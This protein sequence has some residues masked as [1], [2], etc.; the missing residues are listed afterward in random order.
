VRAI[1]RDDRERILEALRGERTEGVRIR[2]LRSDG[3]ERPVQVEV[4]AIHDGEGHEARRLLTAE[5]VDALQASLD[6]GQCDQLGQV[7]N[8]LFTFVGVLT[9]DGTLVKVN[10][11]PVEAGGL[12]EGDV[13]GKK[14]WDCDW[15]NYDPA[16][17]AR[18]RAACEGAARGVSSRYDV[19]VRMARG[20]LM[21][22]DFMIA[23][24][25]D[26]SGHVTHLVPSGVDVTERVEAEQALRESKT[27]A[28][29]QLSE[30][31]AT[32]DAAPIGLCVLDT[33]LRWVRINQCLAAMN[34]YPVEAHIGR[35][36]RELLPDLAGQSEDLLRKI[37]ETGRPVLNLEFEGET[38]AQPGVRRAWIENFLPIRDGEGKIV[39]I[40]VVCE[41]ITERK[42]AE[43]AL[44]RSHERTSLVLAAGRMGTWEWDIEAD[45][46]TWSDEVFEMLRLERDQF[47]GDLS[48]LL[49][50]IVP[51]DRQNAIS[52]VKS[53]LCNGD[54]Y[55]V[56]CRVIRAD[57]VERRIRGNGVI[58]RDDRGRP[59]SV[60]GI[61]SDQ[62]EQFEA[63]EALRR[64]ETRLR[65]LI[66]ANIIGI[67]VWEAS[68]EIT[69]ANEAFLNLLGFDRDDLRAGRVRWDTLTP[70]EHRPRALAA[71]E[72]LRATGIRPPYEKEFFRKDGRTVPVLV[73]AAT[74][75]E[76]G[77]RPGCLSSS[78]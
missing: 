77:V 68:G 78:T 6:R 27:T 53:A 7:L 33:E 40:N 51:E 11:A 64:S 75:Q 30:I 2:L 41:E 71:M 19:Q 20:L 31:Q 44:R 58:R 18:L 42:K 61:C 38:P 36:V 21:T 39:G 62:T 47:D 54:G 9:P 60:V 56:E 45:Q 12:T 14:F 59:R 25:Y 66:N 26:R 8:T 5:P 49:K 32:Y 35:S 3:C 63:A 10:N 73:S 17:Q 50:R 69:E 13:L 43:E 65:R 28:L 22:V 76:G 34:G 16:V 70:P 37:L 55:E 72:R 1:H 23:P 52:T 57:G 24:M 15:W 29:R 67:M 46:I 4:R 74:F 48:S